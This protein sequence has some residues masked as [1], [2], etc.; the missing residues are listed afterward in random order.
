M[1]LYTRDA[2]NG[3]GA[4]ATAVLDAFPEASAAAIALISCTLDALCRQD[5][6]DAICESE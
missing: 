3:Y 2:N 1:I 4:E 5:M 6:V